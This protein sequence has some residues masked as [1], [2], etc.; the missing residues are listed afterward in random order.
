[1]TSKLKC[2]TPWNIQDHLKTDDERVEYLRAALE[3]KDKE[4]IAIAL[5]DIAESLDI[6]MEI[7]EDFEPRIRV[8][9]GENPATATIICQ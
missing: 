1:M 7:A 5:R 9:D 3:E 4:F 8:H 6:E 2:P